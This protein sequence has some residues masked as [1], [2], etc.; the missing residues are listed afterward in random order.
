MISKSTSITR[1]AIKLSDSIRWWRFEDANNP[2]AESVPATIVIPVIFVLRRNPLSL[3]VVLVFG[4]FLGYSI[5]SYR[6]WQ[7]KKFTD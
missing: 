3:L 7:S 5:S 6:D 4:V 2:A 1:L